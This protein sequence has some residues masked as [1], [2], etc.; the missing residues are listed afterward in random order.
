[1]NLEE[2]IEKA[3]E[4]FLV[5][6]AQKEL[7]DVLYNRLRQYEQSVQNKLNELRS[8]VEEAVFFVRKDL[9]VPMDKPYVLKDNGNGTVS[10]VP[11]EIGSGSAGVTPPINVGD[12]QK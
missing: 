5:R 7:L 8:A 1:M 2:K 9:G 12:E 3:V 10:F 4:T 11:Q 6:P